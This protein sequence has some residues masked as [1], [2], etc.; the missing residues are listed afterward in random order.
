MLIV[1]SF[2]ELG[3]WI[4]RI[5]TNICLKNSTYYLRKASDIGEIA[6]LRCCPLKCI[7]LIFHHCCPALTL[8]LWEDSQKG[9]GLIFLCVY[10]L[11]SKEDTPCGV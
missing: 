4:I 1:H 5:D 3:F 6:P 7:C 10:L 8:L 11:S 9:A 2:E